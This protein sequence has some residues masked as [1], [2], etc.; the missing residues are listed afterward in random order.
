MI[1][2]GH[3]RQPPA[4]TTKRLKKTATSTV[5]SVRK[6]RQSLRTPTASLPLHHH[7][8]AELSKNGVARQ[9]LP[10]KDEPAPRKPPGAGVVFI[11][12]LRLRRE[13]DERPE[14]GKLSRER[15]EVPQRAI[16]YV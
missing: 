6:G 3:L 10:S 15:K 4:G 1:P 2:P 16:G 14:V 5:L 12:G 13:I 7:P 9:S 8:H 11:A